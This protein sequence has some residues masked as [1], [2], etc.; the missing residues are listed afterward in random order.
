MVTAGD[1]LRY[2]QT[3]RRTFLAKRQSGGRNV[4]KQRALY[5]LQGRKRVSYSRKRERQHPTR[6]PWR[7]TSNETSRNVGSR[8]GVYKRGVWEPK[9]FNER[10]TAVNEQEMSSFEEASLKTEQLFNKRDT[11]VDEQER[12]SLG[13]GCP[14]T[15]LW[16]ENGVYRGRG[17]KRNPI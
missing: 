2:A 3:R 12:S 16:D 14:R 1:T 10:D 4:V 6:G 15:E 17:G 7:Q 11:V 5:L 9:R 8:T 13:E